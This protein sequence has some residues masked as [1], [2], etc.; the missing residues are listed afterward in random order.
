MRKLHEQ[1]KLKRKMKVMQKSVNNGRKR[2]IFE[3]GD[4]I[5]VNMRKERFPLQ[6][7]SKLQPRDDGHFQVLSTINDNA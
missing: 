7:K 4:W 6:R 5:W 3:L 2:V 1:V